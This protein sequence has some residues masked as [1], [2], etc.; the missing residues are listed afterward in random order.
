[1][2]VTQGKDDITI[3]KDDNGRWI[4]GI[5]DR[6]ADLPTSGIP[7]GALAYDVSSQ[8]LLAFSSG[9]WASLAPTLGAIASGAITSSGAISGTALS[10]TT[11]SLTS[12]LKQA[13]QVLTDDGAI[14]AKGGVVIL[15]KGS[16]IA[17]TLAN[18]TA[19]TDDGKLLQIMAITAQAHT[20]SNVGG[21][22]FNGA[23][24]G[25][26]LATFG[27]AIGDSLILLAYQA[28]WYILNSINITL[29]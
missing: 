12:D 17:A 2:Q 16:A 23:G 22:G 5:C 6:S 1:V 4:F 20:V 13:V 26:D 14:T 18:P 8:Q 29:S 11:L 27:G 24:A 25:S 28:K 21:A 15:N 10:G 9:A 19:T 7:T 3:L